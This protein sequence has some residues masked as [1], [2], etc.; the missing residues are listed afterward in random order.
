M[1]QARIP[2]CHQAKLWKLWRLQEVGAYLKGATFLISWGW[3][4]RLAIDDRQWQEDKWN[5]KKRK[6]QGER[7]RTR[8][9]R[10][11]REEQSWLKKD[12]DGRSQGWK[13]ETRSASNDTEG[14]E[15]KEGGW[16]GKE[17]EGSSDDWSTRDSWK[18]N[19][20]AHGSV[21]SAWTTESETSITYSITLRTTLI[22]EI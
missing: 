18:R 12:R 7:P 10:S 8:A 19:G 13:G 20:W 15:S 21:E 1:G 22:S 16:R 3:W 17:V 9:L 6:K 5:H 4:R 11:L 14:G 2:S